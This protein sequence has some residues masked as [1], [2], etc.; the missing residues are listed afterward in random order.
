VGQWT[1]YLN[2]HEV[3]VYERLTEQFRATGTRTQPRTRASFAVIVNHLERDPEAPD[4]RIALAHWWAFHPLA[5][6]PAGDRFLREAE[7]LLA[8]LSDLG[9]LD[10]HPRVKARVE[11]RQR[12]LEANHA[13]HEKGLHA[14]ARALA[15]ITRH[16]D[17]KQD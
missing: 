12:A 16:Q 5:G 13:R 7:A 10:A 11:A 4:R 17:V 15:Q 6:R 14:L 1:D 9:L 2:A 8:S 3:A